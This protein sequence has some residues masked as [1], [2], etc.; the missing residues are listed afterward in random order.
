MTNSR[1]KYD[2]S[3]ISYKI[4]LQFLSAQ[5]IY[6]RVRF[7]VLK[8]EFAVEAIIIFIEHKK[9]IERYINFTQNPVKWFAIHLP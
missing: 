5:I 6:N 8:S 1:L 3:V 9:S 2:L 7:K 4:I